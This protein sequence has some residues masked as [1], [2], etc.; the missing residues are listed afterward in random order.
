MKDPLDLKLDEYFNKF[1]D[2]FPMMRYTL[3]SPKIIKL[4]DKCIKKNKPI[5]VIDPPPKDVNY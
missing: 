3:E 2:V 1:G 4:I 5:D